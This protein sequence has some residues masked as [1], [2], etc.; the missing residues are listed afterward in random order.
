[1]RIRNTG[2]CPFG[3]YCGRVGQGEMFLSGGMMVATA[4]EQGTDSTYYNVIFNPISSDGLVSNYAWFDTHES[5]YVIRRDATFSLVANIAVRNDSGSGSRKVKVSMFRNG[6]PNDVV[7]SSGGN[8]SMANRET[9]IFFLSTGEQHFNKGDRFTVVLI[10]ERQSN[11]PHF[12]IPNGSFSI[13]YL[14]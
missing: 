11:P 13:E 1:M 12:Y 4:P 5:A 9:H 3:G 2:A 10:S 8:V 7:A 6:N 14:E